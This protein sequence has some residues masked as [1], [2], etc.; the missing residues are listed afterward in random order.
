[1]RGFFI[2]HAVFQKL[3][4][5]SESEQVDLNQLVYLNATASFSVCKGFCLDQPSVVCV[6]AEAGREPLQLSFGDYEAWESVLGAENT[7][8]KDFDQE[9]LE[10]LHHRYE[11]QDVSVDPDPDQICLVSYTEFEE[12]VASVTL[13]ID[14]ISDIRNFLL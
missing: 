3:I 8:V 2:D 12:G 10:Q 14:L 5:R 11:D 13:P 9:G 6:L 1:M 7:Y 4:N